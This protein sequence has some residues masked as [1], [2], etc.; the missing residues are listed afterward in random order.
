MKKKILYFVAALGLMTSFSS[1]NDFGD[2]NTDPEAI[3][4]GV[5]DY[6]LVFTNVQQYCYGTEYEAWRNGLIYASTMLQ[7]TASTQSYWNGDKYTYSSGYNSAYWDRMYPNGVRDVIDL[8]KNWDGNQ[9]YYAEYQMARILKV[10]LFH[11]MT[12]MYGD[13]PYTQSGKGYYE[14]LGYPVYDTQE[15]IYLDM[16]KELDESA[17]NLNGLSSTI[18]EADIMYNGNVAKW[19]KLAYSLMVRLSMRL[20]KV[21]PETA[22]EWVAK[23]VAGGVFADNDDNALVEHPAASTSNNSSEPFGKIYCHEDPGAYRMSASFINL[24]KSTKDPRLTFLSTI[25]NKPS[26]KIGGGKWEMGD[27]IAANQIGMPNGYDELGLKSATDIHYAPNFPG[28]DSTVVDGKKVLLK[29]GI[30]KYAVVN[31]YTYARIDAP[32]FIVTHAETQLLLAEAAYRGWIGGSAATYYNNG[33]TAAMK[34]FQQFGITGISDA[35]IQAYLTANPYNS[36]KALEQINTQY[37]INTFSDEYETFAN[38]RRSGY[39]VL[40]P[41]N[42]IGN[43]TGG[44]IPRRFTYPTEESTINSKNYNE[45]VSRLKGGDKM[46]SRVWWDAE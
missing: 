25:V 20:S 16:L 36:A 7:H 38:W 46:T 42:Y 28:D 8:L 13:I 41:V 43:V 12:D 15:A 26:E 37:Y 3:G 17:K 27:T 45:A 11:R 6:K 30:D 21:D 19:Q 44:T 34:Q 39:P 2:V 1:C 18:S 40:T 32:T 14:S 31:R 24:L 35:Q 9:T 22:K 10:I 23:A 29:A 33:V 4:S 5:M